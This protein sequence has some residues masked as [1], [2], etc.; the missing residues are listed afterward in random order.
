MKALRVSADLT[1]SCHAVATYQASQ[2]IYDCFDKVMVLYEG[3]QIYFGPCNKAK[4]Y[5]VRMGWH[6][7]A[8]QIVGDF[9]TSVT[10]PQERKAREGMEE[11][12]PRTCEEFETYWK[13]SPEYAELLEAIKLYQTD[14][15]LG[16]HGQEDVTAGKHMEQAKHVR[17]GSPY[18]ISVP[19]Q[20]KLCMIRAYQRY[21]NLL[22]CS[23]LPRGLGNGGR[24]LTWL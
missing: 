13:K 16:G 15:P 22:R 10:N 1:G 17:P 8:R 18:L 4:D 24:W 23:S 12:V 19:M 7:P 14:Y 11:K 3:R 9:L 6:I 20:L 5:F 2:A 21:V